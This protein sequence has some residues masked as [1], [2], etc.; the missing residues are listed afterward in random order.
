MSFK[1]E[2]S[3]FKQEDSSSK[4]E[5]PTGRVRQSQKFLLKLRILHC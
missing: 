4:H 5:V 1:Q 2:D 3:S